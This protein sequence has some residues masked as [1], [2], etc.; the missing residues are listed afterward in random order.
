MPAFHKLTS[1]GVILRVLILVLTVIT[2]SICMLIALLRAL[3]ARV[4][5]TLA[6]A[7]GRA[8]VFH[9]VSRGEQC[10]THIVPAALRP[11]SAAHRRGAGFPTRDWVSKL[12]VNNWLLILERRAYVGGNREESVFLSV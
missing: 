2:V 9:T 3:S 7:I 4:R 12:S 8:A 1:L 5:F 11:D 10:L 6:Y